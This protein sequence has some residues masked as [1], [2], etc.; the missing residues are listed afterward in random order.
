MH[1]K[2]KLI[3]LDGTDGSG[4]TTQAHLLV[5]RLRQNGHK[6]KLADFPQYGHKSAGLIENYLTGQYGEAD[7]VDPYIASLFYALDRYDFSF[8]LNNWLNAGCHVISNRYVAS[9]M[10]HQAGKIKNKKQRQ[11]FLRWLDELEYNLLRIPQPDLNIILHVPAEI[12]QKLVDHKG[13][14]AYLN[15]QKRDQ[16]EKNRQ[17]LLNAEKSYLEVAK[18]FPKFQLIECARNGEIMARKE[19]HGKIWEAIKNIL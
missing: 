13:P 11:K 14:R 4:K 6:V 5:N 10:G 7:K 12:A 18:T 2:G 17:H 15:G 19:I 1:K 8:K 16:H 9:S 3:V